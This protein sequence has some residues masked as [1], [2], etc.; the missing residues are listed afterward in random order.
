MG[1]LAPPLLE[2]G[3]VK[4]PFT[5]TEESHLGNLPLL[6]ETDV[7]CGGR[8]HGMKRHLLFYLG[9]RGQN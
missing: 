2:T 7:A 6:V 4:L 3:F 8:T 1:L 5:A 9:R